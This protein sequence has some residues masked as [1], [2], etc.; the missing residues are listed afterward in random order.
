[1]NDQYIKVYITPD[2][3]AGLVWA[4]NVARVN[5]KNNL[6]QAYRTGNDLSIDIA[7]DEDNLIATSQKLAQD[8]WDRMDVQNVD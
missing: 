4:L 6:M 8:L 5:S 3:I 7:A 1:M 2:E